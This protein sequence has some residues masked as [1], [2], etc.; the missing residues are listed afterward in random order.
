MLFHMRKIS[1]SYL[2]FSVTLFFSDVHCLSVSELAVLVSYFSE[3][4][5][6]FVH[7]V[8]AEILANSSTS[9]T[10]I[11]AYSETVIH[12]MRKLSDI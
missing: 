7:E 12:V 5:E 1:Y 10:W 11:S 2:S 3:N 4:F 9:T 8:H 6:K